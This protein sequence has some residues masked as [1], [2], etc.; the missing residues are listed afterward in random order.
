MRYKKDYNIEIGSL[1]N[2]VPYFRVSYKGEY[3]ITPD[4]DLEDYQMILLMVLDAQDLIESC[5]R[6]IKNAPF[7]SILDSKITDFSSELCVRTM[8]ILRYYN[9]TTVRELVRSN[10]PYLMSLRG[11]GKKTIS[12]LY[13]FLSNHNLHFNMDV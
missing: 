3:K 12:E 5:I 10:I 1:V 11:C 2:N 4:L 7:T 13:D 8:N 9:V 6:E